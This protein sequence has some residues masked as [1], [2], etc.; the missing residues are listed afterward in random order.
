MYMNVALGIRLGLFG[1]QQISGVV[2]LCARRADL[3]HTA[4]CGVAVDVRI[5]ALH[6]A[7][8]GIHICNFVNGVHQAGFC[9]SDA[10]AL[11]TVQDILLCGIFKPGV[12]QLLLGNILNLLNARVFLRQS[13][14]PPPHSARHQRGLLG[15]AF[16]GG[17]ERF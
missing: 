1:S 17:F 8:T 10:C 9:L 5:V 3:Q 15:I 13:L 7:L 2:C 12:H 14:Q 16:P 6:I 4:H 11:S